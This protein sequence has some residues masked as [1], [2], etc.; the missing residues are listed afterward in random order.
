MNKSFFLLLLMTGSILN[1]RFG[2]FGVSDLLLSS[3]LI[4]LALINR[5]KISKN[6]IL[7]AIP[8]F[9]LYFLSGFFAGYSS[10][11][12]LINFIGFIYKYLFLIGVFIFCMNIKIDKK[13]LDRSV[14]AS[15]FILVLWSFYYVAFYLNVADLIKPNQISFPGTGNADAN[16]PDSHLFAYVVGALGLYLFLNTKR[17]NW[18]YILISLIV[19][20]MTGSRNPLFLYML[21]LI[22][23]FFR[24]KPHLS[25]SVALSLVLGLYAFNIY[26]FEYLEDLLPTMRSLSFDFQNDQSIGNR[27]AKLDIAVKEFSESFFIFGPSALSSSITWADGIHT[28]LIIHFGPVGLFIYLILICYF[29]IKIS[30]MQK[31]GLIDPSTFYYSVYVIFGLFVTEFVFVSRGAILVLI[32][33]FILAFTKSNKNFERHL[34]KL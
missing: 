33:L 2:Y 18:L 7:I 34:S 10:D 13:A 8:F 25:I 3:A 27:F 11:R 4:Y 32:P 22:S 21:V 12:G 6:I 16:S 23:F 28:A 17:F 5:M 15:W 30:R 14:L 1:Y 29:F 31:L 9:I 26:F 24:T 19:I 20:L